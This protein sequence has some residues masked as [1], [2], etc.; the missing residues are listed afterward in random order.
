MSPVAIG[1]TLLVT[2]LVIVAFILVS[3]WLRQRIDWKSLP[4][5]PGVKYVDFSEQVDPTRLANAVNYALVALR[6]KTN[7]EPAAIARLDGTLHVAIQRVE[8]WHA[9]GPNGQ[10]FGVGGQAAGSTVYI[11]PSLTSLLHEMVHVLEMAEK[12]G[13]PDYDHDTWQARG[14]WAADDL[15]RKGL[16][17]LGARP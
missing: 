6:Q 13:E 2:M 1:L 9:V 3:A 16:S 17:S 14:V 10:R 4:Q 12:T 7:F 11:G 5:K 15:Y 8:E